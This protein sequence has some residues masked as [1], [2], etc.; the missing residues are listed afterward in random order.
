MSELLKLDRLVFGWINADCSNAVFDVAM[1]WITH[2]GDAIFVWFW[3][4]IISL[5]MGWQLA[6]LLKVGHNPERYRTILKPVALVCLYMALIFGVNA[7]IYRGLKHQ[8][9]R[10]RPFVQQTVML[11]VSHEA[12][13]A[14]REN[15]SFPS[16]HAA[17]AFMVAVLLADRLRRKHYRYG[18]LG[19]AALVAFSRV[20][21]GVHYPG[22]VLVGA[23]LGLSI[24]M[25][26]LRFRP[27]SHRMMNESGM[28]GSKNPSV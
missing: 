11:R 9:Q 1:P 20:Y 4:A 12:G 17:N 2:L 26:M 16:G 7:G 19:V 25:L 24:T 23:L 10:S 21:L 22:D 13:A 5:L 6:C 15:S 14:L 3:I 18:L 8:F 28:P 27:L